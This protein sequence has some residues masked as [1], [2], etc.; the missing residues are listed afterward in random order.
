MAKKEKYGVLFVDKKDVKNCNNKKCNVAFSLMV[1]KNHCRK[2]GNV[3]CSGC[4][5]TKLLVDGSKNKKPICD[6][7]VAEECHKST[8]VP[9]VVLSNRCSKFDG[10]DG[11]E[12]ASDFEEDAE[13]ETIIC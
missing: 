8:F 7:C 12:P 6:K 1:G 9:S 5:R 13:E 10:A 2:C 3:F 11:S 4:T